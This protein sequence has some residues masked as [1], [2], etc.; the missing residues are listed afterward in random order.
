MIKIEARE[1]LGNVIVVMVCHHGWT[2]RTGH[3]L[4]SEI[5]DIDGEDAYQLLVAVQDTI[6]TMLRERG[7]ILC[8]VDEGRLE[9]AK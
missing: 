9:L 1:I 7:D 3:A 4:C 6:T 2:D 8:H 5:V